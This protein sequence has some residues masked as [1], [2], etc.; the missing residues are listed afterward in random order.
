MPM[1]YTPAG[2]PVMTL[3]IEHEQD[4]QESGVLR[5]VKFE[6]AVTVIGDLALMHKSLALG[7]TIEVEGFIAPVRKNSPRLVLHAQQLRLI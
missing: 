1:R 7:Q 6:M 2:V 3:D 4:V 5:L